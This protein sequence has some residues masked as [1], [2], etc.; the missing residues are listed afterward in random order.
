MQEQTLPCWMPDLAVATGQVPKMRSQTRCKHNV[1][2]TTVQQ[3]LSEILQNERPYG[4]APGSLSRAIKITMAREVFHSWTA[5]MVIPPHTLA[6][7]SGP[8]PH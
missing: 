1:F 8:L 4:G 6:C 5:F 7:L 2:L 3:R